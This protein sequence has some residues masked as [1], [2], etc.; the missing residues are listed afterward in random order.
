ML[1]IQAPSATLDT[2]AAARDV[3]EAAEACRDICVA[4][5]ITGRAVK[6]FGSPDD[7]QVPGVRA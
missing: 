7:M 2:E 4:C 6:V 1:P 3:A 5:V